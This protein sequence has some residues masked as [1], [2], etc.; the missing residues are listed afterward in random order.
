[1][2]TNNDF[3]EIKKWQ[4]WD[5][6]PKIVGDDA[7]PI[8]NTNEWERYVERFNY[9]SHLI[10][11]VHEPKL[12]PWGRPMLPYITEF[13]KTPKMWGPN[14]WPHPPL[15]DMDT[16]SCMT[17]TS[18]NGFAVKLYRRKA[19]WV[20]PW[21]RVECKKLGI[22]LSEFYDLKRNNKNK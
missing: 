4:F 8:I 20:D 10:A 3:I 18:V 12:D 11:I 21:H 1:M 15:D 17:I 19:D 16:E 22:T 2:K 14:S 13:D 6:Y 9:R 7:F 5:I